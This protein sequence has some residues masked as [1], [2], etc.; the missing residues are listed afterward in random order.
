MSPERYFLSASGTCYQ[1]AAKRVLWMENIL[2]QIQL[3]QRFPTFLPPGTSFVEDNFSTDLWG[4]G[5]WVVWDD[6]SAL[7]LLGTLFIL[8][9]WQPHLRSSGIRSPRLGTPDIEH[10]S[11]ESEHR[12]GHFLWSRHWCY[13]LQ[14][15]VRSGREG[16]LGP[17]A[18]RCCWKQMMNSGFI[19]QPEVSPPLLT[20]T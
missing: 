18:E 16:V 17:S 11:T 13:C 7:H 3:Q 5:W 10:T 20:K 6:S 12:A 1:V 2:T 15:M 4:A 8:L 9:L 14:F 19:P